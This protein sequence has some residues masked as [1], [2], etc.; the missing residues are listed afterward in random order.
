M[1]FVENSVEIRLFRSTHRGRTKDE[2]EIERVQIIWVFGSCADWRPL[3]QQSGEHA[4]R[5]FRWSSGPDISWCNC[6]VF[7]NGFC[8]K[9]KSSAYGVGT[10]A[11]YSWIWDP[12]FV[13]IL[14]LGVAHEFVFFILLTSRI[15]PGLKLRSKNGDWRDSPWVTQSWRVFNVLVPQIASATGILTWFTSQVKGSWVSEIG[16]LSNLLL[17]SCLFV[18][19][20][21]L[22]SWLVL[23]DSLAPAAPR[24]LIVVWDFCF[25][26]PTWM[27]VSL[28]QL[29]EDCMKRG[30]KVSV[31]FQLFDYFDN[32][33]DARCLAGRE[34]H[35]GHCRKTFRS[36]N[37]TW[38]FP[39]CP[40]LTVWH[41][42]LAV[43]E[44]GLRVIPG[45]QR[46]V[47]SLF[48]HWWWGP[49]C[50]KNRGWTKE[51]QCE[52]LIFAMGI[53]LAACIG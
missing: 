33:L 53:N 51:R 16:F 39:S 10:L 49:W 7:I 11:T 8:S 15:Y 36:K 47:F 6:S 34:E 35:C 44:L 21:C 14:V 40:G 23:W 46:E 4:P 24:S 45:T 22:P 37:V 28:Y 19:Q 26:P 9:S 41:A 50:E 17:L 20:S 2:K 1:R 29:H 38:L 18:P 52:I 42:S 48:W 3:W 43:E 12:S 25:G 31:V 13:V 5:L 30:A 32:K 27:I